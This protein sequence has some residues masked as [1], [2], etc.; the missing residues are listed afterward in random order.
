MTEATTTLTR[1]E[2]QH[3]T[4]RGIG[5]AGAALFEAECFFDFF[6]VNDVVERHVFQR[7]P[8]WKRSKITSVGT[9]DRVKTGRPKDRRGSMTTDF[10]CSAVW[11]EVRL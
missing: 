1:A 4:N 6:F 3:S 7:I 2:A 10:G 9:A 11:S 5:S 8:A